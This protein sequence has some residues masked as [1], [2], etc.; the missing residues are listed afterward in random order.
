LGFGSLPLGYREQLLQALAG[1]N[2][3]LRGVH[4]GIIAHVSEPRAGGGTRAGIRVTVET[5]NT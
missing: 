3:L 4:G 5:A 1:G 2:G